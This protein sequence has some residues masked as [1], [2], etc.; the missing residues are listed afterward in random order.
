MKNKCGDPLRKLVADSYQV[1]VVVDMVD[2][3]AVH[4]EVIAYP[5]VAVECQFLASH[6]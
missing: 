3:P 6:E 5:A 1:E 2:T 4:S